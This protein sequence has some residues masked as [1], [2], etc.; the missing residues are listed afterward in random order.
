M[1]DTLKKKSKSKARTWN[2]VHLK[3]MRATLFQKTTIKH[4]PKVQIL[5]QGFRETIADIMVWHYLKAIFTPYQNW[6]LWNKSEIFLPRSAWWTKS[7]LIYRWP[8]G[9]ITSISHCG[10]LPRLPAPWRQTM[11]IH[12]LSWNSSSQQTPSSYLKH[13][14]CI[15]RRK[16]EEQA[17]QKCLCVM[18]LGFGSLQYCWIQVVVKLLL[19][20]GKNKVLIKVKK[21]KII[22]V[23][24][25]KSQKKLWHVFLLFLIFCL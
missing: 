7:W 24:P 9:F 8:Q 16:V 2:Q 5:F 3:L 10:L 14:I 4:G 17:D 25:G 20:F 19:C 6:C 22:N 12:L 21:W 15:G 23:S 18:L 13:C 11:P 1:F